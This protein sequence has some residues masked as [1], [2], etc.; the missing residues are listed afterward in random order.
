MV[1]GPAAAFAQVPRTEFQRYFRA[2]RVTGI[3]FFIT[4]KNIG[5]DWLTVSPTRALGQ[6]VPVRWFIPIAAAGQV[7]GLAGFDRR[8]SLEKELGHETSFHFFVGSPGSAV[9]LLTQLAV[10]TAS[11]ASLYWDGGMTG[12]NN[13]GN[14]TWS[15][16]ATTNWYNNTADQ[17]WADY[18]DAYFA[19]TAGT[20]TVS[21]TVNVN[22][23][24]FT[25][26]GY[27]LGGGTIN[28]SSTG[29]AVSIGSGL[30]ET[31]NS[32]MTG[33]GTT[34]MTLAGGGTLVLGSTSN[35]FGGTLALNSGTLSISASGNLG[36]G[37]LSFNGGTLMVTGANTFSLSSSQTVAVSAGGGTFNLANSSTVT[38]PGNLSGSGAL[39]VTSTGAGTGTLSLGGS[40]SGYN[41]AITITQGSSNLTT[42]M[43]TQRQR[44]RQRHQ[45]YH[46]R[47]HTQH[48]HRHG[49]ELR[50]PHRHDDLDSDKPEPDWGLSRGHYRCARQRHPHTIKFRRHFR[51]RW[52]VLQQRS[53]HP[54]HYREHQRDGGG[55]VPRHQ[56]RLHHHQRHHQYHLL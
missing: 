3:Y 32:A 42:L 8:V 5:L 14:G 17:A 21:G 11:G 9:L 13:G 44:P 41:G 16:S 25:T 53:R 54:Q 6:T 19:G 15:L 23:L 29:G 48:R 28:M 12:G 10:T 50:D 20:V 37:L 1:A 26:G 55:R 39:L 30:T 27:T 2:N 45:R 47:Q 24:N 33:A 40:N 46:Q 56:R 43:V 4:I 52:P 36:N 34:S 7:S 49:P 31:I 38:I 35:S 22:S 18:S 51:G